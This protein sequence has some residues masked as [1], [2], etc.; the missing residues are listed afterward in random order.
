M[1]AKAAEHS[2]AQLGAFTPHCQAKR[3]NNSRGSLTNVSLGAAQH[4]PLQKAAQR[5]TPLRVGAAQ[6]PLQQCPPGGI[7]VEGLVGQKLQQ[8]L[9]TK[10]L[11][12]TG[13][14]HS[15]CHSSVRN[16]ID[17]WWP[18]GIVSKNTY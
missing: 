15:K 4:D 8:A 6:G 10:V 3:V 17:T 2:R 9:H 13:C 7:V 12:G 18:C 14:Q 1:Q 11:S 5:Q 16:V